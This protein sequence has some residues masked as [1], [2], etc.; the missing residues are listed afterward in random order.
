MMPF[1]GLR[2]AVSINSRRVSLVVT[3]LNRCNKVARV[4]LH[5]VNANRIPIQFLGPAPK[6]IY[7]IGCLAATFSGRN[8]KQKKLGIH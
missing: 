3:M 7:T 4:S 8:L 5:S 6:G 2:E 1:L